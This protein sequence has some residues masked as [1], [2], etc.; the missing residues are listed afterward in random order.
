VR[1]AYFSFAIPIVLGLAIPPGRKVV[2]EPSSHWAVK[3]QRNTL[4]V[5][6]DLT[7]HSPVQVI[8][9]CTFIVNFYDKNGKFIES[10]SLDFTDDDDY[11]TLRGGH[12]YKRDFEIIL[13][14]HSAPF[15]VFNAV[16][17]QGR[18]LEFTMQPRVAKK[19][20]KKE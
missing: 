4:H 8:Q 17:A 6:L 7:E 1:R 11:S 19:A 5:T 3:L 20:K 18:K 2:V 13:H 14:P 12:V 10:Q 16:T 15:N 9:N